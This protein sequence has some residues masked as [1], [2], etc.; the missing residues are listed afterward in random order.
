[1]ELRV[2]CRRAFATI[3]SVWLLAAALTFSG[4]SSAQAQA[5]DAQIK[6]LQDQINQLQRAINELKANQAQSAAQAKAAQDQ[7]K[8]ADEKAAAAA[9]QA[10]QAQTV[11]SATVP[12]R[13][14]VTALG[15]PYPAEGTPPGIR[16]NVAGQ[17]FQLYGKAHLSAIAYN[18]GNKGGWEIESNQSYLGFRTAREI[19]SNLSF[20]AQIE[21]EFSMANSPTLKDTFGYRDTFVGFRS[22]QWGIIAGGKHNTP[23]K[24]ALLA[25]DPFYNTL[26]DARAL[27]GNTG[28]DNRVEFSLRAPHAVWYIAP[29]TKTA[30]GTVGGSVLLSPGQNASSVNQD[31]AFGENI[32]AGATPGPAGPFSSGTGQPGSGGSGSGRGDC[33]DGGF[34]NLASAE[35]H[36]TNAGWLL[37]TAFEFHDGTNRLGDESGDPAVAPFPGTVGVKNE[38]GVQ[39]LGGRDWGNGWKTYLGFDSLN[40]SDVTAEFNE[41]SKMD[42]LAATSW[43]FLPKHKVAASYVHATNTPGDPAFFPSNNNHADHYAVGYFYNL[44][45]ELQLFSVAA[46]TVNGQTAH[47]DVGASGVAQPILS[48]KADNTVFTG[49]TIYGLQFGLDYSF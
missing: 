17:E 25:I 10:N 30:F 15:T 18:Q 12:P 47:Y 11:V 40:R 43:Q 48:R 23:Y 5:T 2:R 1:M 22:S 39:V 9:A 26:G 16:F 3:G 35:V 45:P 14:A 6:A 31:F 29:E 27:F 13:P 49:K 34:G 7:A 36:W 4:G 33:N 24:S 41:R 19:S 21:G 20:I 46:M 32:C 8:A 37:S 38:W 28:G 44:L 42:F